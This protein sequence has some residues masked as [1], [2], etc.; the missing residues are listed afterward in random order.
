[1]ENNTEEALSLDEIV[2]RLRELVAHVRD[3]KDVP[4]DPVG[5]AT[6][7]GESRDFQAQSPT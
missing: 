2:E 6:W 5:I 1:M 3:L 4:L 7:V